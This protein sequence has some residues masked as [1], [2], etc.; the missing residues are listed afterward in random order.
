MH[1]SLR[2]G[3]LDAIV[4]EI[5]EHLQDAVG[6]GVDKRKPVVHADFQANLLF[7]GGGSH[8]GNCLLDQIRDDNAAW[9][10]TDFPRLRPGCL[11]QVADHGAQ[12][13][14]AVQHRSEVV[15]LLGVDV[16]RQAVQQDGDELMNAGQRRPQF[17]RNVREELIL[18]FQLLVAAHLQG[19][20]QR[21]P[22]HGVAHGALQLAAGDIAFDQVVLH[23][24]VHGLHGQ[25]FVVLAGE[26]YHRHVR[27]LS[28][29]TLRKVSA[30]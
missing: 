9:F 30:P 3:E 7:L 8:H 15:T 17:V 28:R 18:E 19:A 20:K 23:T 29:S 26:D 16:A 14:H 11:Q 10:D 12:L 13:V 2:R 1:R 24:L 6:I 21:L 25:R 22:F 27:E 5:D 4:D